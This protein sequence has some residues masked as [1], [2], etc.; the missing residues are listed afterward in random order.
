MADTNYK[1]I[2]HVFCGKNKLQ[3]PSYTCEDE[4]GSFYCEVKNTYF[5]FALN[6]ACYQLRVEGL[7]FIGC[8]EAKNKK[9]A[10]IMAAKAFC[11]YLVAEK[12]LQPNVR[13]R[14]HVSL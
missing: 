2:L 11:E 4:G 6:F 3:Q 13:C 12:R 8:G 1:Q 7:D 10:Q 9:E 14:C 5:V